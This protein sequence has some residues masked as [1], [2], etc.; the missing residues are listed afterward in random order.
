MEDT[1]GVHRTP[2]CGTLSTGLNPY[3]NGRYS[4]RKNFGLY[5]DHI[6]CLNPYYNGRYSWSLNYNKMDTKNFGLS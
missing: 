6:L 3:Y 4:W 1:H 5:K 2:T